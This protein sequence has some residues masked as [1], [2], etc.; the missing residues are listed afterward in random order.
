VH[1]VLAEILLVFT[2]RSG[3]STTIY[4]SGPT[5]NDL[6]ARLISERAAQ[7]I[8]VI[9]R[10]TNDAENIEGCP[11]SPV[12]EFEYFAESSGVAG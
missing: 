12:R 5:S 10:G 11:Q 3:M 4:D 6:L 1:V 9:A 8:Q 2:A 7:N